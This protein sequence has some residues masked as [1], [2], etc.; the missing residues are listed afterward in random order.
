MDP[1][2]RHARPG[3]RLALLSIVG[4][5]ALAFPAATS[6]GKG[7]GTTTS[8]WIALGSVTDGTAAATTQPKLG[9]SVQFATG[10][11][12]NTRNPWVSLMCYQDGAL[13][14][15][16]GGTPDHTFVLGGASSDWLQAGGAASCR[17]ELGDLYWKG[18]YEYYTY[19]A[20]TSF[21]A[22]AP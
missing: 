22:A 13:V 11:A 10:Y 20:D 5:V 4:I 15:G 21:G 9:S 6:A 16:E 3:R 17:A 8:P 1:V 18:G 19:L 2:E 14:Y 7:G 12:K